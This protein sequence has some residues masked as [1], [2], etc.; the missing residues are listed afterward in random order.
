MEKLYIVVRSDL[1]PGP[2][3]AQTAHA[4]IQFTLENYELVKNWNA[5]SNNLAVLAAHDEASLAELLELDAVKTPV[6]E[7]DLQDALTAIAFGPEARRSLSWLPLAPRRV[8]A[9]QQHVSSTS[10]S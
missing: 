1:L 2:Q 6:R 5:D 3:L 4:A 7:P 10:H 8:K 9:P